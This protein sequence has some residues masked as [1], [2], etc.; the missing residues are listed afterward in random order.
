MDEGRNEF[1]E[2]YAMFRIFFHITINHFQCARENCIKNA[3]NFTID[4]ALENK[5]NLKKILFHNI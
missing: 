4:G 5:R 3:N 2:V 1:K